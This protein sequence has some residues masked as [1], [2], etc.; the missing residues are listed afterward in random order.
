MIA[1]ADA[2]ALRDVIRRGHSAAP[3]AA[4][5]RG[6]R[7]VRAQIWGSSFIRACSISRCSSSRRSSRVLQY[8]E[9]FGLFDM[10]AWFTPESARRRPAISSLRVTLVLIP[11]L[12]ILGLVSGVVRT[13]ARD[14]GF[15]LTRTQAG[16]RRRRGLFT[17]SEVVIPVRR[18]QV[19]LIESGPIARRLGW[20]SLSFQTLG[21]DQKEGGVQVAAPF[22]RMEEIAADPRRGGLSDAAAARG[23][24]PR[25]APRPCPLGRPLAA[26]WRGGRRVGPAGRA[27]RR[28]CRRPAAGV[29]PVRRA[30]LAQA[31]LCARRARPV[32]HRAAS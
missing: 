24:R 12:L 20:Y 25:P 13:V 16:L 9:Q 7:A 23:V 31:R 17:L 30:A 27:A 10:E 1:L 5:G 26:L 3:P 8:L 19:A 29:R 28:H 32:R 2:Y 14:F 18:T 11:L 4:A 22:A 21:A 6:A 15:R